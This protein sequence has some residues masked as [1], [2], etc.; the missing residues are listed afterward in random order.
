MLPLGATLEDAHTHTERLSDRVPTACTAIGNHRHTHRRRHA[1]M[2]TF[3]L[4]GD[5]LN[6]NTIS[7]EADI[8]PPPP[9]MLSP[10]CGHDLGDRH[11]QVCAIRMSI[12]INKLTLI[13]CLITHQHILIRSKT[14]CTQHSLGSQDLPEAADVIELLNVVHVDLDRA[15]AALHVDLLVTDSALHCGVHLRKSCGH[16]LVWLSKWSPQVVVIVN[17]VRWSQ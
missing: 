2:Q 12:K 10:H 5:D 9:P 17:C 3:E 13:C 6:N 8:S 11:L 15:L 4:V 1:H 7:G 14:R 16:K